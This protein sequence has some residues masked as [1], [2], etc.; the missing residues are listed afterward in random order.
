MS[1]HKSELKDFWR[2][3]VKPLIFL[4]IPALIL[5]KIQN[6]LSVTLVIST[7]TFVMMLMSGVRILHFVLA[8]GVG[9][10]GKGLSFQVQ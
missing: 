3:F 6:H 10:A 7:V 2:G 4:L 8:G 1:D 9:I 5:Y